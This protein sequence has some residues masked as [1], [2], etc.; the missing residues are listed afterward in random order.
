MREERCSR[1]DTVHLSNF[2]IAVSSFAALAGVALASYQILAPQEAGQTPVQ[3]TV[4]LD[5]GN[6]AGAA[7]G[8]VDDM[9]ETAS[10]DLVAR[11]S[12]SAAL[13]D[14]SDQ[15]YRLSD[16]F[17][18]KPESFVTVLPPDSEL[19]VLVNFGPH[20]PEVVTA[21][22]YAP[23]PGSDPMRLATQLDV[24]VIPEGSIE[25]SGRPVLSFSLQ[26][27]PGSQTFAIPGHVAGVGVWL[28]IAGPSGIDRMSVGDFRIL[29]EGAAP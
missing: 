11:A 28:R 3:V 5:G 17:D 19:N 16:L 6:D 22:E 10:I 2:H 27:S 18:G 24:T 14:G 8:D 4:A 1:S 21:I 26:T 9:I 25:A 12:F 15:R 7:K 13:K 20:D 23:P 29:K